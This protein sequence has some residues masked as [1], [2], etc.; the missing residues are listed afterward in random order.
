MILLLLAAV[1][2]APELPQAPESTR[3][4][5]VEG[6][7]GP[8]SGTAAR[9][10]LLAGVAHAE[11]VK[12]SG[13]SAI[14]LVIVAAKFEWDLKS[15][16][17]AFRE[18]VKVTRGPVTLTAD[19]LDVKY[20]DQDHID[21]LTARGHVVVTRGGRV[22]RAENATLT[23]GDGRVVLTGSPTLTEGVNALSGD[24]IEV[25]LDDERATCSGGDEPCRLT[26]VGGGM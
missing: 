5:A 14:P 22:A 17:T 4:T 23:A 15:Q 10:E 8:W 1:A 26:I 9:V 6:A 3:L 7:L 2:C 25:F 11:D 24:R 18:N 19:T 13:D 12:V 20:K 21:V 16:T